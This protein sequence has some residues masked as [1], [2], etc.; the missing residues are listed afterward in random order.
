MYLLPN[1]NTSVSVILPEI[2]TI[3][4][5]T[6]ADLLCKST[7]QPNL[8]TKNPQYARHSLVDAEQ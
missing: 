1:L 3:L 6:T 5:T 4:D 8:I 2:H 7:L